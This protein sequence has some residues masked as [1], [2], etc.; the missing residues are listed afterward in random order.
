[1]LKAI[2]SIAHDIL[3]GLAIIALGFACASAIVFSLV[4]LAGKVVGVI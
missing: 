3:A 4:V 2:K 1:M